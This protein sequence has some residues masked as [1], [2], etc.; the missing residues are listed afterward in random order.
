MI[1]TKKNGLWMMQQQLLVPHKLTRLGRTLDGP[2]PGHLTVFPW[3]RHPAS[4]QCGF[5]GEL[6]DRHACK[7]WTQD[8]STVKSSNGQTN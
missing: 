2:D 3:D 5:N 8:A 6:E 1:S 7:R 4:E